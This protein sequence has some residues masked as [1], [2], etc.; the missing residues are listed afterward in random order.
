LKQGILKSSKVT[1]ALGSRIS[2]SPAEMQEN[3]RKS[4]RIGNSD[5]VLTHDPINKAKSVD[6]KQTKKFFFYSPDFTA[7]KF[8]FR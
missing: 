6:D 3:P 8:I 5:K 2:E 7:F 4:A 1:L